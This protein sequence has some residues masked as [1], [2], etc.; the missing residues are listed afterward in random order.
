[1]ARLSDFIA[2]GITAA[3][4]ARMREKG[5]ILQLRRGLYQAADHALETHHVLAEASKIVPKGIVCLISALAFH[6]LTDIMPP[7]VWMAISSRARKPS[8]TYPPMEFVRFKEQALH[9]GIE[10]QL[11]EGVSVPITNPA[12]TIVDLFRYRRSEGR[13]F[14]KSPGI[15][16][17]LESMREALRQRKATPADIAHYALEAGNWNVIEPYLEAMTANV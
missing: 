8:I 5:Q 13:R 15:T 12:R 2:A 16:V 9:T 14:G 10:R 17:A 3:T 4:I 7:R 11:I 1:M 6:D